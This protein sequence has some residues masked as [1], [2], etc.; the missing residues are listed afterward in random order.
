M[1]NL[2]GN[3]HT[4]EIQFPTGLLF[5]Y[6]YNEGAIKDFGYANFLLGEGIKYVVG[7]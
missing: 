6:K 1:N 5:W 7:G 3:F 4:F 2:K